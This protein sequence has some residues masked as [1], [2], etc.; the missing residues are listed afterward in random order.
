MVGCL[1]HR[2]SG[3]PVGAGQLSPSGRMAE[4]VTDLAHVRA[5]GQARFSWSSSGPREWQLERE[6]AVRRVRARERVVAAEARVA[7]AAAVR[8]ERLVDAVE[9]QVRERVG[10]QLGGDLLDLATVGD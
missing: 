3:L 4:A 7:V 10:A 6:L 8:S 2:K 5:R 9:R 1:W